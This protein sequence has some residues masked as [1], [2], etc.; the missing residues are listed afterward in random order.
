MLVFP[1]FI[2]IALADAS[3]AERACTAVLRDPIAVTEVQAAIEDGLDP[4]QTCAV[5]RV[6]NRGLSFGEVLMGALLPPLGLML[7]MNPGKT[8]KTS[9]IPLLSLAIGHG[10]GPTVD[11]LLDAG[12]DPFLAL[13][14]HNAPLRAGVRADLRA[15]SVRWTHTL[16][17]ERHLPEGALCSD[18]R[19]LDDLFDHPDVL[20]RLEQAGL[21]P[22]GQDCHG[23][24][25]LHRAADRG[26]L[27]RVEHL[28]ATGRIPVDLPDHQHRTA[29]YLAARRNHWEVVQVLDDAGADRL[30]A[31]GDQGSLLHEAVRAH[32][33]DLVEALAAQGA[34]LAQK[35]ASGTTPLGMAV[36][37]SDGEMV[38][39]L[40]R[41]GV[42]ANEEPTLLQRAVEH[43]DVVSTR[44]LLAA[45]L[46]ANMATPFGRDLFDL[47]YRR[48]H[49]EVA[50]ILIEAGGRPG[51]GRDRRFRH[52]DPP[53]LQSA[54]EEQK[55]QWVDVLLPA[56]TGHDG[57]TLLLWSLRNQ[58]WDIA[59]QVLPR[60]ADPS[61]VLAMRATYDEGASTDWLLAHGVR[62]DRHALDILVPLASAEQVALALEHGAS[63]TGRDTDWRRGPLWEAI[64]AD[65]PDLVEL[66]VAAGA[67]VPTDGWKQLLR[68]R[69]L[70]PARLLLSAGAAPPGELGEWVLTQRNEALPML[71]IPKMTLTS[72]ELR[73]LRWH[74]WLKGAPKDLQQHLRTRARDKRREEA[75]AEASSEPAQ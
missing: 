54:F 3:P 49:L 68:A 46:P 50:V 58:H 11:A 56:T 48:N 47:A 66:L 25:W 65:R 57:D 64:Q 30:K 20:Q 39:L 69:D 26:D 14:S 4:N 28:V 67:A 55:S 21:P 70:A 27:D 15:D 59:E 42:D 63:P 2:G 16:L 53:I 1:F 31:G 40:L 72:R 71:V 38:D 12:A 6:V 34:P 19:L 75:A 37:E 18:T 74:A 7:I 8:T 44:S 61:G 13:D 45:G 24:T 36:R 17:A 51:A 43:G 22:G 29:I 23:G 32:K 9:H 52:P 41:L 35:D 60:A 62:Y 5:S 33:A 10:S 73:R